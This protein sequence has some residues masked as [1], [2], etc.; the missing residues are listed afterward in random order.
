MMVRW[1]PPSADC[2]PVA[3]SCKHAR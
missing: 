2:I 1:H 3:L